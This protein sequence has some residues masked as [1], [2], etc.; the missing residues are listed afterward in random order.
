DDHVALDDLISNCFSF[1]LPKGHTTPGDTIINPLAVLV[2]ASVI[3]GNTHVANRT[4]RR[5][6]VQLHITNVARKSHCAHLLVLLN[7]CCTIPAN[8]DP[9]FFLL[10]F[11]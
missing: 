3:L 2:F 5:C 9:W 6:E 4:T 7:L 10:I 11:R 1:P 8:T